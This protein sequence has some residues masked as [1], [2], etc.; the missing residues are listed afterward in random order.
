MSTKVDLSD[1]AVVDAIDRILSQQTQCTESTNP[2]LLLTHAGLTNKIRV[3]E[4]GDSFDEFID[5]LSEGRIMYGL[6]KFNIHGVYKIAF[7]SWCPDGVDGVTK[8]KFGVWNKDMEWH[9]KGK[10]HTQVMARQEE[11]IDRQQM[12]QKFKVA[13]GSSYATTGVKVNERN[14]VNTAKQSISVQQE[15]IKSGAGVQRTVSDYRDEHLKKESEQFWSKQQQQ[16]QEQQ[17]QQKSTTTTTRSELSQ[18]KQQSEQFWSQHKD[19]P[20]SSTGASTTGSAREELAHIKQQSNQF[21][22]QQQQQQQESNKTS[23]S[24]AAPSIKADVSALRN[25][26][27]QQAQVSEPSHQPPPQ[28]PAPSSSGGVSSLRDRFAQ[29]QQQEEQEQEQ[30]QVLPPVPS[31]TQQSRLPPPPSFGGASRYDEEEE[32]EQEEQEEQEEEQY[33]PEPEP[34][35]PPVPTMMTPPNM[36]PPNM[37]N[38]QDD[39]DD[40]GFD[41]PEPASTYQV[42]SPTG[43]NGEPG[44][45]Y[46]A[47]YDFETEDKEELSF[48]EEDILVVVESEGDWWRAYRQADISKN[49]GLVPAN[50]LEPC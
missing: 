5:E 25:K 4:T 47:M 45:K 30:Q 32:Q 44:V 10:Y 11:D 22:Q 6:M 33:Q 42:P 2:W 46:R 48:F 50:Y 17:Q 26:F 41:E 34:V 23:S 13:T 43:A 15:Q 31:S 16:Q 18:I 24:V 20:S 49:V 7:I 40:D 14:T 39:E 38:H 19:Q 37:V 29:Q 27:A 8:G 28:R 35:L 21:W 12:I 36:I 1:K 3:A 9:L